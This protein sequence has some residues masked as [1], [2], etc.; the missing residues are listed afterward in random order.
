MVAEEHGDVGSTIHG[1]DSV[2]S[3]NDACEAC[4]DTTT[5]VCTGVRDQIGDTQ[6]ATAHEFIMEGIFGLGKEQVVRG[7]KVDE[8]RVV[9]DQ[10]RHATL[11]G[12]LTK[13]GDF[14]IA[15]RFG[16]PLLLVFAKNLD[17]VAP[18]RFAIGKGPR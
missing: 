13:C 9:D 18:S 4:L 1:Q 3:S 14:G 5:H 12:C 6:L 8:V 7:C 2:E 17:G 10:R 16:L 15:E 11:C